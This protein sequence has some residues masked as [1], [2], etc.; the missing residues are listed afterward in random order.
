MVTVQQN[1]SCCF[2]ANVT[3]TG[4]F[5]VKLQTFRHCILPSSESLFGTE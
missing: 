4:S 3:A 1:K 5:P 2:Y